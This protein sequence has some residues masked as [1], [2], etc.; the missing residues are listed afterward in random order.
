MGWLRGRGKTQQ[1]KNATGVTRTTF[2]G[3]QVE[4]A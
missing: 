4:M 1:E 3:N 2:K